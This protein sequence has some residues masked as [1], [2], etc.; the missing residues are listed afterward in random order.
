MIIYNLVESVEGVE[1]GFLISSPRGYYNLMHIA[2]KEIFLYVIPFRWK[3]IP[4]TTLHDILVFL[5]LATNVR[6]QMGI[7]KQNLRGTTEV[8]QMNECKR[9]KKMR[10]KTGVM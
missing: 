7:G 4:V 8:V 9:R 6:A 2:M 10:G 5:L 1:L 3:E